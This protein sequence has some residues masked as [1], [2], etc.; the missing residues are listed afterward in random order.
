MKLYARRSQSEITPFFYDFILMLSSTLENMLE[1]KIPNK[2]R[3][4]P[5][6]T[7][8]TEKSALRIAQNKSGSL[9]H[10]CQWSNQNNVFRSSFFTPF[11]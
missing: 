7:K 5:N 6:T 3:D 4:I 1:E 10:L 11:P 9:L 2:I 8:E